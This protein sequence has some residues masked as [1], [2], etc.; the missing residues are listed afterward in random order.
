[1]KRYWCSWYET[2]QDYRP[3]KVEGAPKWWC[4]GETCEEPPRA[5]LCAVVDA[6]GEADAFS[7]LD[8]FWPGATSAERRFCEERAADWMPD[9]TRFP[10][11]P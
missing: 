9:H 1:M 4:S 6:E 11:K 3:I 5:T 7:L 10:V 8:K 2:S